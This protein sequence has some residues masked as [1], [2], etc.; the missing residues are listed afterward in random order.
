[1]CKTAAGLCLDKAVFRVSRLEPKGINT[2]E[3]EGAVRYIERRTGIP[4]SKEL[5]PSEVAVVEQLMN[6]S[7]AAVRLVSTKGRWLD[8]SGQE[9]QQEDGNWRR[10]SAAA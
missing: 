2:P 4:L 7:D 10:R 1:L 3:V 9:W 5:D 6:L 8:D